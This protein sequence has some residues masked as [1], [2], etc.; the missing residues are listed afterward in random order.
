M[1]LGIELLCRRWHFYTRQL[2]ITEYVDFHK[3][4]HFDGNFEIRKYS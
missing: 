1:K 3:A 2:Y 4:P